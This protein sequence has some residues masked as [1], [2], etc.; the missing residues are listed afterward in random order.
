MNKRRFFITGLLLIV[1]MSFVFANGTEESTTP[2]TGTGGQGSVLVGDPSEQYY[3]ITFTSGQDYWKSCYEGFEEAGAQF[4]IETV[5]AGDPTPDVAKQVTVF[6]QVAARQPMGI[7]VTC[8]NAEA[9]R[10]SINRAVADGIAVVTFD[11][12]SPDSDRATYLATGNEEAGAA[13]AE[14]LASVMPEG[15]NVALLYM[16][17]TENSEARAKGFEDWT[18]ENPDSKLTVVAKVN[19]RG[20]QTEAA[21]NMSAQLQADPSINAIVCLDSPASL[22]AP[23]VVQ[24]AGRTDITIVTFD[25][26]TAILDMIKNGQIAATLAQGTYNMGYLSMKF[27]YDMAHDLPAKALPSY[28]D[29]GITVVTAENADEYYM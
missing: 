28:I 29:T 6:D 25:T 7:A 22:A 15:G 1:A 18:L 27:L 11:S 26:D 17:G 20:E 14:Y 21:R 8:A 5:Y 3:M 10:E 24:E 13:A 9:L 19:D 12:D 23:T 4:G 16:V 2:A